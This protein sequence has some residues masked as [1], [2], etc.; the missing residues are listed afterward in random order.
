MAPQSTATI[1]PPSENIADVNKRRQ[2][3]VLAALFTVMFFT[4]GGTINPLPV[5]LTPLIKQY[6]WSHARVSWVPTVYLLM[7]GLGAPVI[8]WLMDRFEARIVMLIGALVAVAGMACA[9]LTHSFLPMIGA[10]VLIG[11]VGEFDHCSKPGG[12]GELVLRKSRIGDQRDHCRCGDG[13]RAHAGL[14]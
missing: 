6:G 12:R 14:R 3:L 5:F 7:F 9:S 11:A 10:F 2:W 8:G 13:R 4:L 1:T